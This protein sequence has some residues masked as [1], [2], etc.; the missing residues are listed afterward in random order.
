MSK[1]TRE[2]RR[3]ELA[4]YNALD[5]QYAKLPVILCQG[6]CYDQCTVAPISVSEEYRLD[7]ESGTGPHNLL[8]RMESLIKGNRPADMRCPLL[9]ADNR[10]SQYRLRPLTCRAYGVV[11]DLTCP[12][13]CEIVD[14]REL[15][16]LEESKVIAVAVRDIDVSRL[17][18]LHTPIQKPGTVARPEGNKGMSRKD[19]RKLDEFNERFKEL[20]AKGIFR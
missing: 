16:T 19:R 1:Q 8:A 2:K 15:L 9:T 10:C 11:A 5:E 7:K 13:G 12:H 6:K 14:N 17:R 20:Q 18:E 3:I 4:I